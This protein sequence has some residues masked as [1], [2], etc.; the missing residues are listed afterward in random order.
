[1]VAVIRVALAAKIILK[2]RLLLGLL[3]RGK[4]QAKVVKSQHPQP[5]EK[6]K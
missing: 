3:F 6:E 1:M 4:Q 2:A 5:T